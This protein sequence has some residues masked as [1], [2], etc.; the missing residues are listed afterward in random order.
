MFEAWELIP[1]KHPFSPYPSAM[2]PPQPGY[3]AY[4]DDPYSL[5]NLP[6]NPGPSTSRRKGRASAS[7]AIQ[8]QQQQQQQFLIGS[9]QQQPQQQQRGNHILPPHQG[10]GPSSAVMIDGGPMDHS[11]HSL[12]RTVNAKMSRGNGAGARGSL[13]H[14]GGPGMGSSNASGRG[15][16][17]QSQQQQMQQQQQEREMSPDGGPNMKRKREVQDRVHK[18]ARDRYEKRDEYAI[19]SSS[20]SLFS[21]HSPSLLIYVLRHP[22]E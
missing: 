11:H 15:A 8:Q 18:Y 3:F 17:R 20:S 6:Q 22:V 12:E 4:T 14:G 5:D 21:P 13:A 16:P 10:G 9:Q 1:N 2:P 19:Q 7:A